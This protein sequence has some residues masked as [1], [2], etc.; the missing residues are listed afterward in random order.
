MSKLYL[1]GQCPDYAY[2]RA[3]SVFSLKDSRTVIL[4][5]QDFL[6]DLT[7]NVDLLFTFSS[8]IRLI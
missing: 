2:A 5:R 6:P 3:S 1:N 7:A 8:N 4:T